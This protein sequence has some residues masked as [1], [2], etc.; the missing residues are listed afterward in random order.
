MIILKKIIVSHKMVSLIAI[1]LLVGCFRP[2]QKLLTAPEDSRFKKIVITEDLFWPMGFEIS[3]E[4]II[5]L[6]ESGGKLKIIDPS[7]GNSKI[8]GTLQLFEPTEYG[9]IGMALDPDFLNNHWIYFQYGLPN[10]IKR[11]SVTFQISRFKLIADSLDLSS[12]KKMVQI[13]YANFCCHTAGSMGFDSKGN[14]YFS[15]GDNTNAFETTYSPSDERIGHEIA[16]ALR[17]AANS[18]DLRGKILRIHPEPNGSYTIPKDNLFADG[19]NGRPEI[20]IMGCRNP[21]RIYIDKQTDILYWGEVGPDADKDSVRGPKGYDE[22]NIAKKA[23]FYGWPLFIG[24]NKPYKRINFETGELISTFD[25][26][27]P[28]NYSRLNNGIK[29]LPLPNPAVIWYPYDS[30]KE[31][32]SF[33]VGGRTAIGGPLYHFDSDS[34]SKGKFPEYFD[35]CWF[36]AD[37]MRNFIKVV[38]LKEGEKITS[39]DSFMSSSSFKKPIDMAFGKD[40]NLYMI[41]YGSN[42]ISNT[43]SRLVKIEYISG[44]RNPIAEISSQGE[45]GA[46]PFNVTLSAKNSMDPDKDSLKYLWSIDNEKNISDRENFSYNISTPGKHDITLTATDPSGAIDKKSISVYAGNAM[47]DVHISLLNET[48]YWEKV[49]YSVQVIDKEDGKLGKEILSNQVFV[50]L[51]TMPR[52]TLLTNKKNEK[53]FQ[54]GEVFI[55][56]SD[57]KGCHS[58]NAKSIGPSFE[59]IAKKYENNDS[60]LSRLAEKILRG[61]NGSWGNQAMAPHPQL[62]KDRTTEMVKYILS[63]SKPKTSYRKLD[64]QGV[65]SF[66]WGNLQ[67]GKEN[68]YLLSASYKDKGAF[69][70][71]PIIVVKKY[72]LRYPK[73]YGDDF[74][75]LFES[76]IRDHKLLG[77]MGSYAKLSNIDLASIK[78]IVLKTNGNGII[79][80]HLDNF[81]GTLI[82]EAK[83]N[84]LDKLIIVPV[85]IPS[86]VANTGKRD[87]YFVRKNDKSRFSEYTIEWVYFSNLIDEVFK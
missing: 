37:W 5:Y 18:R 55:N 47:P 22:F 54:R 59:M 4:G 23:G 49:P 24:N 20:Y 77:R 60:N 66:P 30:S 38:H 36:I 33:G 87:I 35:G 57:C 3:D 71:D 86:I 43:D 21:Y 25:D 58:V 68:N 63:L 12:E 50:Q 29:E 44:N 45:Y 46:L 82:G 2:K 64:I 78:Q 56:E 79:E 76:N 9:L 31:F 62:T 70:V 28:I 8:A 53:I 67:I 65:I 34:K 84:S 10:T 16:N 81:D 1:I 48:F 15:T 75:D 80:I 14:L 73:L 11:D 85:N 51:T 27:N 6:I 17:S 19:I 69:Q 41:E 52:N 13:P 7:T 74:E 39:I 83:V 32:P 26:K 61:G 42:W 40:G 72:L